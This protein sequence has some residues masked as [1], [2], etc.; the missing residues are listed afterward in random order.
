MASTDP[1]RRETEDK[2]EEVCV[3]TTV[4]H[5]SK[6][7]PLVLLQVNCRSVCNRV[8]EFC[9]LIDPYSPDVIGTESWLTEEINNAEIFRD[10]YITFRRARCSRG[11]GVL[12]CAKNYIA[13][14]ELWTDEDYEMIA[15]E[16]KGRNPNVTWE[17]VGIY[18]APNEDM[19]DVE[20]L[21]DRN[22]YTGISTKR[23]IFGG[24]FN[25]PYADWNVN[26]GEN[27]GTQAII[28]S[29]VWENV[30][31]QVID[32]PTRGDA[33]L[34]VY[35]VRPEGSV[36]SSSTVQGTSDHHGVILKFEMEED[37]WEPQV[38]RIFPVYNKTDVLGLQTF[39]REKFAVWASNGS[40]VEEIWNNFKNTA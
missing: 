7:K 35:L 27:S 2:S 3:A 20:R 18:R 13:C 14:R 36:T 29:L 16:V 1:E 24:N 28:N 30:Y 10:D 8:L 37:F 19:S 9:I 21:A 15:I 22:G 26:V 12:I 25:L 39:L 4:G 17:V 34:D 11:G 5:I 23:S 33:V 31:S 32:S 6:G 40:S 38:E